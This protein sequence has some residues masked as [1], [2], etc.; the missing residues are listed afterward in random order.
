[1]PYLNPKYTEMSVLLQNSVTPPLKEI[2]FLSE[3]LKRYLIVESRY[4]IGI[5]GFNVPLDTI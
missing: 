5:V 2:Y 1:M 4:G 3:K